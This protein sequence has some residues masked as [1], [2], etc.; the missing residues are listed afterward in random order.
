LPVPV[1]ARMSAFSPR[2]MTG[3]PNRCGEVGASKTARNQA[4]VTGWKQANGLGILSGLGGAGIM[5]LERDYRERGSEY[6]AKS[7]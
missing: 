2:A 1:G 7:G 3:Q 6:E 5:V 4:A